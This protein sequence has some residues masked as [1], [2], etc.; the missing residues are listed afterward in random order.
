MP[1]FSNMAKQSTVKGATA[2]RPKGRP[3]GQQS[4][5]RF[6]YYDLAEAVR[7]ATVVHE[8]GGG[9][10]DKTQLAAL[11]GHKAKT[12]GSF[13][14]RIAATKMFGLIDQGSD[15]KYR[16]TPRGKAII[17]P[18][19][20]GHATRAKVDAFLAVELFSKVYRQLE[21]A[22]LPDETGLQNLFENDYGIVRSR[23][24]PTVR[25][26]LKSAKYAGLFD[27]AG[28]E[29]MVIPPA[30]PDGYQDHRAETPQG[31]DDALGDSDS[32]SGES[33]SGEG[34]GRS[35]TSPIDP[36]IAGLLQR[37]PPGGTPLSAK[38]R[39]QLV[40]A[41]THVVAFV[42]PDPEGDG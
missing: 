21:D 42:Y 7:V 31:G 18:V 26:M 25:I 19:T 32:S 38:R 33:G 1:E 34:A 27:T 15:Y 40:T 14:H 28:K 17:A 13:A 36:A 16:V 35:S 8:K 39:E 24:A 11:L 30:L 20:P 5:T 41:F 12:S 6:P 9:V 29:R 4:R 22:S 23:R 3:K 37:L 10:C 2:G